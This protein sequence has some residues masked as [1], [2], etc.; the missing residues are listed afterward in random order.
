VQRASRG[1]GDA[2]PPSL[3][4]QRVVVLGDHRLE[5]EG[6][7]EVQGSVVVG[8]HFEVDGGG[9]VG[10]GR[11][12]Q[13]VQH[14]PPDA[15]S[16]VAGVDD[17]AVD[18]GP[19]PFADQPDGAD[20]LAVPFDHEGVRVAAG[21][22]GRLPTES[23]AQ[24]FSYYLLVSVD[25]GADGDVGIGGDLGGFAEQLEGMLAVVEATAS[26]LRE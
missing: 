2:G 12:A 9:A 13:P 21:V 7:V 11:S 23:Q 20:R 8:G 19:I 5:A 17:E 14:V 1:P 10:A 16:L 6:R 22:L 4:R 26:P 18:A 3:A 25:G 15:A 24:E